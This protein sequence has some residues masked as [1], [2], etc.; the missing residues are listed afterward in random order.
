MAARG[1]HSS[2][3]EIQKDV[4][5]LKKPLKALHRKKKEMVFCKRLISA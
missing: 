5:K 2:G 4:R 1:V 3:R